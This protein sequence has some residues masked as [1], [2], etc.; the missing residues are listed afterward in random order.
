MR[1][2]VLTISLLVTGPILAKPVVNQLDWTFDDREFSGY[3]IYDDESN[4][5]RPGLAMV[6]NWMGINDSAV[7]KAK[8]IAGKE[9]V[10]LLVDMYGKDVRPTDFSSASAAAKAVYADPEQMRGR[11]LRAVDI[12]RAQAGKAP[13]DASKLG[14]IGFCFGGSTV[15]ELARAGAPVSGVVSFHGGLK[16][17]LPAGKDD[18]RAPVLVLNGQDDTNV[19]ADDI[20]AFTREMNSAGAYWQ[21]VN[22]PGAHH[23]F[24]EADANSPPNCLYHEPSAKRAYVLMHEFF[25]TQFK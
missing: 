9:Y 1:A 24:A 22:F 19:S 12:L 25:D 7:E 15:L 5:I 2:L 8:A 6:P 4:A 10:V 3:V 11:I 17:A 13:L 20:D 23:C 14:A 16:T 18:I 21:L